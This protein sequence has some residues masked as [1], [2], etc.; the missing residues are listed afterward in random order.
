MEFQKRILITLVIGV[1]L[2]SV[3]FVI[4]SSITKYTG[5]S[6][7]NANEDFKSCL[8]EQKIILYINT[9]KV[10]ET[11]KDIALIQYF[12]YIKIK[13]CFRDNN[14]CIEDGIDSFPT[15]VIK[16]NK[17]NRDITS[18]ELAS[19]SGCELKKG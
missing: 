5:F 15:W 19:L 14:V 13:N 6:V 16:N 18:G 2:I 4:T 9:E 7:S 3:F 12:E 1:V 10:S 17:I 8:E 11:L